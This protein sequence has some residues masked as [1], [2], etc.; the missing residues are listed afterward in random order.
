[1]I[2]FWLAQPD[3]QSIA[4]YCN[5]WRNAGDIQDS[6]A[7]LEGIINVYGNDK[8]KFVEVAGPGH[9]NDPDEVMYIK[10]EKKLLFEFFVL[11][12]SIL[13]IFE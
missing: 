11:M 5:I 12:C 4:K 6:W 9:F 8:T 2:L 3:Y 10:V 13:Q 7:S 1:M